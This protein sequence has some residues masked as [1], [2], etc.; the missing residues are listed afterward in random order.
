[1]V[2]LEEFASSKVVDRLFYR[3]LWHSNSTATAYFE[4]KVTVS[5]T[6]HIKILVPGEGVEPSSSDE[7]KFLKLSCLPFH[8]PGVNLILVPRSGIEP[9]MTFQ[10]VDFK[11]TGSANSPT[12]AHLK[13][14]SDNFWY[15]RKASNLQNT[16]FL[17][18]PL[19]QFAYSGTYYL[20]FS[21]SSMTTTLIFPL[22]MK[23]ENV[24]LTSPLYAA[25][26]KCSSVIRSNRNLSDANTTSSTPLLFESILSSNIAPL[27]KKLLAESREHD[28][29]T[30]SSPI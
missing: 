19:C 15:P 30:L 6:L 21:W 18:M 5:A 14:C 26:Q 2:P 29:Q 3:Q 8:Q 7:Q 4:S 13:T 16:S 17:A 24:V 12:R 11:S 22:S 27:I 10:S 23:A 9:P 28:S 25:I 20:H 1:M